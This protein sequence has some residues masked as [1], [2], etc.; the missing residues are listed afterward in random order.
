M[1]KGFAKIKGLG[2]I[3]WHAKHEM[4]HVLLGLLWAWLM[5]EVWGELSM[6]WVMVAIFG[7]LLPDADHLLYFFTY[8]K[9]DLYSKQILSM[10]KERHWRLLTVYIEHGHKTNINLTYHN[11]YFA[12]FLFILCLVSYFYDWKTSVIFL[13]AMLTHYIFDVIDDILFLGHVNANWKRWGSI[14]K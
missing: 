12:S 8:G 13:G 11:Y 10:V 4:V 2:Y 6:R 7:S 9:R 5:R 3:M 14:R 1:R